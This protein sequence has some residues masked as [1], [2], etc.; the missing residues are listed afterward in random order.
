MKNNV[1]ISNI[2][3]LI[4]AVDKYNLSKDIIDDVK[5]RINTWE[6]NNE[7]NIELYTQQ[8]F[9]FIEVYINMFK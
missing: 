3:E 9:N 2:Q 1:K 6:K 4:D 8:Q 5:K 7:P